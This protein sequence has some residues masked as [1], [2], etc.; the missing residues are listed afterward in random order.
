MGMKAPAKGQAQERR[1]NIGYHSNSSGYVALVTALNWR[2]YDC[3]PRT[4]YRCRRI[5]RLSSICI[6]GSFATPAFLRGRSCFER[7]GRSCECSCMCMKCKILRKGLPRYDGSPES[8]SMIG[9]IT[10][11][12]RVSNIVAR[13]SLNLSIGVLQPG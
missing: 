4:V 13:T 11:Q 9:L 10:A 5:S 3:D 8:V 2:K 7:Y 6:V 12:D 1:A